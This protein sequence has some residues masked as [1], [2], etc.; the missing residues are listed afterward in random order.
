MAEDIIPTTIVGIKRLAKTFS[1]RGNL[2]HTAA[3]DHVARIAGFSNFQHASK[4]LALGKP[5]HDISESDWSCTLVSGATQK[6]VD[7]TIAALIQAEI[8]KGGSVSVYGNQ[9]LSDHLGALG[10]PKDRFWNARND[11]F[12]WLRPDHRIHGNPEL[13]FWARLREDPSAIVV[14]KLADRG[15][16]PNSGTAENR[17][18]ILGEMFA[19]GYSVVT[20]VVAEIPADAIKEFAS[21]SDKLWPFL[22]DNIK[23]L[24]H[25]HNGKDH[26]V[27][28]QGSFS[29]LA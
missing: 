18:D 14:Q 15:R 23:R 20:G 24:R 12:T 28:F 4:A 17:K 13:K 22:D 16:F 25:C 1:R 2:S 19:I 21:G 26:S 6:S 29:A 9:Q 27:Q 5:A 10:L 3:L 7:A 8:A 11:E